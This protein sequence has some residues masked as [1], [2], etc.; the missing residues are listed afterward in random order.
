MAEDDLSRR[1]SASQHSFLRVAFCHLI[2]C[3]AVT[4]S[5]RERYVQSCFLAV[6]SLDVWCPTQRASEDGA[7]Q[8]IY[9]FAGTYSNG[10]HTVV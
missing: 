8:C 2:V 5:Q 6:A 7:L 4:E 10:L 9:P 1:S 3:L